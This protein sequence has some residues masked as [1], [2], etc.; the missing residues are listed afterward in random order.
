MMQRREIKD[1]SRMVSPSN[2]RWVMIALV[3]FATVINYLDRQALSVVAPVLIEIYHMS[4]VT[5]S[6]IIFAFML[7][8]TLMNGVTGPIIDRVG[9]R[10][11]YFLTTAWWSVAAM[12]H[13]ATI[14]PWSLGTFRF[15]LGMG[16]A[17]N[18]PAG[19]KVVAEWFPAPERAL[20][21]G[22]FN[23]GSAIGAILAPPIVVWVVLRFG[24]R[25]TFVVVGASGFIWLAAWLSIYHSPENIPHEQSSPGVSLR[26][27]L[28]TR[29]IWM[30]TGAKVFLDPVWYFYIFWFP[31]YLKQARH[32]DLT[33]IGKWAWIPFLG[34]AVGNVLGGWCAT[35]LLRWHVAVP[36]A[37]KLSVTLFALL[38]SAAIPA[39]LAN[40]VRLS[41]A[42][43][44][45]A[46]LG[47]TGV[48][49]NMLAVPADVLPSDLVAS[50]WGFA[51]VGSGVGGML[52]ALATGWLVD[53]F[54]YVP[55]FFVFGLIPICALIII[56][57]VMGPLHPIHADGIKGKTVRL[58]AATE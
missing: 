26:Q 29:F 32:F 17:G 11:G 36:L 56:W 48:T 19:V 58:R 13:A 52:F 43:V 31:A 57:T 49:A 50:A 7:A 33:A 8:Y 5:Y 34:A 20:A 38:M 6:R 28:A 24:W 16:E 37:R 47:Y 51:S 27:L 1:N 55:V 25:A 42:L 45:I 30:F 15:L 14:G 46:M 12:L 21:S 23:S 10:A 22:I 2:L 9:T 40:D 53:R 4:N 18:W 35:L 54:S 39:V 3:F 44:S 41:I